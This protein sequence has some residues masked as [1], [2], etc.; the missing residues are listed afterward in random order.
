MSGLVFVEGVPGTG[1]STTAQFLARQLIR[2]GRPAR[3]FYEEQ[4]PNPFVPEIDPSEYRDWQHFIDLRVARWQAFAR[5]AAVT[6]ETLVA[7]SVLLQLPMFT[8]LRRDVSP[9]MIE[10]LL[11]ELARTVNPLHPKLIY[12]AHPKPE[13]AWHAIAEQRGAEFVAGAVRRS[14]EWA[15]L[16]SRGLSGLPGVL[17]YWRAHGAL[18]D[19]VVSRLPME[20]LTVD[21]SDGS[22]PERRGRIC[23]FLDVAADEPPAPDPGTLAHVTGRYRNGERELTVTLDGGRLVLRGALWPSNAL[24]PVA[25]NRFDVEAWP[26][27]IRFEEDA[28]GRVRALHWHGPRLWWGGPEGVYHLDPKELE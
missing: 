25:R 3:W 28:G 19:D 1:K 17:A 18:C 27:Q 10:Q 4:V 14:N 26:F 7:E 6:T 16:H 13:E 20:T 12:L 24:L 5:D 15:F 22:W 11:I 9:A 8:M 23:T 2:H 21:M